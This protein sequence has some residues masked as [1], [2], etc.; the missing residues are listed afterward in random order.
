MNLHGDT[1]RR[2]ESPCGSLKVQESKIKPE[3]Q[4]RGE[5]VRSGDWGRCARVVVP[6]AAS[7]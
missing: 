7:V 5:N 4:S 1:E 6:A 2:M 3:R